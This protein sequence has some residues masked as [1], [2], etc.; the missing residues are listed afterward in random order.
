MKIVLACI[1]FS[2]V[3]LSIGSALSESLTYDEVFYLEEGR[4]I[5][6]GAVSRDPY[7]PP[8]MPI[9]TGVPVVL[10]LDAFMSSSSP[11]YK[12]FPARMVTIA[13]GLILIVATY[14]VGARIFGSSVGLVAAFILAFDPNVLANSH[15]VTSDVGVTLFFFLAMGLF[16]RFLARPTR[17][18]SILL[19]FAVGYAVGAKI[20]SFVFIFFASV[21]LLWQEKGR[22]SWRWI[23]K[24]RSM[25]LLC[26]VTTLFFLWAIYFLR[27]DVIIAARPDVNR[28]SF[29]ILRF[30]NERTMPILTKFIDMLRTVPVPLGGFIAL[31]KNNAIRAITAGEA[32]PPWY[33]ILVIVSV[34]TPIP[35]LFLFFVG[36]FFSGQLPE[37]KRRRLYMF[38]SIP[39]I[40]LGVTMALGIAPMVRYVLPMYPFV[41]IVA[42]TSVYFTRTRMSRILLVFLLL[43]YAWGTVWQHP[44]FIS[45]A[46]ELVGPRARRYEV[47]SDSNLDW[48]Q[49]L[50]DLVQYVKDTR[51]GKVTF[52]YFGR[53]DASLYGLQSKTVYGSWRIEDVCAFHDV[54]LDSNTKEE[55]T[56]ISISSW[57]YCGYNK[58]EAFRKE[59]IRDVVADVFLIF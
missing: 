27:S 14:I 51:L 32:R 31:L 6:T 42:A 53:D 49:A 43:W 2:F 21:M 58:E 54:V 26:I 41:A 9:L 11:M 16:I 12:A 45:Y 28:V 10:G 25:V 1:L 57:Y 52:S 15:Y 7:N 36:L 35:L 47:L 20:T 38:G 59:N 13:L 8:L 48:G 34:K 55:R 19:G 46:N 50:P 39:I 22:R 29:R 5:L 37:F 30:A 40:I 24:Q 56:V 3:A 33:R 4:G 23:V 44:H 18:G 17:T